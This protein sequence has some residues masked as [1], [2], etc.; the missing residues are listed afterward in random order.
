MDRYIYMY[1]HMDDHERGK[2]EEKKGGEGG[3]G[4]GSRPVRHLD[5][6]GVNEHAPRV[7]CA[8]IYI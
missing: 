2:E 8:Y 4:E 1:I 6:H 7:V 5:D 3:W